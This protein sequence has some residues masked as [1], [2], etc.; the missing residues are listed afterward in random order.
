L[1]TAEQIASYIERTLLKPDA[2]VAEIEQL[3]AEAR[4]YRLLGVCVHG[5]WI[6]HARVCLQDTPI[7]VVSVAGFPL[8]AA[9]AAVKRF[10]TEI[11]IADGA[12]EVDVVLN[13]G[14]LK[15][16]DDNYV[17]QELRDVVQAAAGRPVKAILETCLLD[18]NEKI[19][20]CRIT[21]E[22]GAQFVKTSTGF[23]AGGATAADVALMRKTVGTNFGNKAAGG[24]RDAKAALAMIE[25]GATRIGA[26]ASVAIIR[27]L[28][29]ESF[30]PK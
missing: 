21:V 2:T 4:Q 19:R 23:S 30:T 3:C 26:S 25:A 1:Q 9:T 28:S 29:A 14:R 24:I 16:G 15:Q 10:E 5:S 7:K 13:I 11:A 12:D 17:L 8:G 18:D 6:R 22:S 27:S 20:A